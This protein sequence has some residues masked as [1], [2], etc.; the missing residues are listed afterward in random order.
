MNTRMRSERGQS[1]VEFAL[2]LPLLLV[3]CLGVVE[4]G[5]ALFNQHTVAKMTREGSNMISRSTSLD[6]TYA[7]LKGMS[8]KPS[9]F[10]DGTKKVIFSVVRQVD[11]IG[12]TNYNFPVLYQRASFGS[13]AD[14]TKI[15]SSASPGAFGGGPEYQATNPNGDSTLRVALP[16]GITLPI[17]G[18]LYITEVYSKHKLITPFDRIGVKLPEKL[19]S[20]AYF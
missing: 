20:I 3:L 5:N 12:A 6:T 14:G 1:L 9:D 13:M 16:N 10:T 2:V 4:A 18:M 8:A 15:S 17:G 19:Y 11:T 7:A